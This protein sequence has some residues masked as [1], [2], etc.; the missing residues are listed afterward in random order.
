MDY[1]LPDSLPLAR[2]R[3]VRVSPI[4]GNSFTVTTSNQV[5][6][7]TYHLVSVGDYLDPY[8]AYVRFNCAHT[9]AGVPIFQKFLEVRIHFFVYKEH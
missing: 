8:T 3:E 2:L 7:L 1:K 9:Y 6:Q 5:L 4:N